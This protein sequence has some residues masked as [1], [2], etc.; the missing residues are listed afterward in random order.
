MFDMSARPMR[1]WVSVAPEGFA[2]D[3]HFEAWV[4]RGVTFAE[5]L[6]PK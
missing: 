1:G 4:D 3:D 2:T 6:P 5:T